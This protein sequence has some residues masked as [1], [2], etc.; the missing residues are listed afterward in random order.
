MNITTVRLSSLILLFALAASLCAQ[1]IEQTVQLT[2]HLKNSDII[3]GDTQLEMIEVETDFGV[4]DFPIDVVNSIRVGLPETDVDKGRLLD[5]LEVLDTGTEDERAAAFDEVVDLDEGAIPFVRAWLEATP[6]PSAADL[7]VRTAYEV[8]LARYH[9]TGDLNVNDVV[10]Y[11]DVYSLEGRIDFDDITIDAGYARLRIDRGEIDLI[12][13]RLVARGLP[14]NKVFKLFANQHI[15]ANDE[16]GWLNTGIL[17]K[18]GETIEI[19]STGQV[20]LASLSGNIYTPDGGVNGTPAPDDLQ[21]AYG[22]VV[23]RVGRNGSPRVAGEAFSGDAERTGI[24]YISI[25]EAVFNPANSGYYN[26]RVRVR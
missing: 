5:L 22:A 24:I 11:N 2:L 9:I 4:M 12:D 1:P 13:V 3:T 25:R 14:N 8:L 20:V 19:E 7:S 26:T 10:I 23:F 21:E 16:D 17:V 15:A 6:Q 18:K